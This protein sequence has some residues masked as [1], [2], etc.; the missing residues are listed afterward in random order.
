L[1]I[2]LSGCAVSRVNR[3]E[4]IMQRRPLPEELRFGQFG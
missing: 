2:L 1:F 3:R 4:L